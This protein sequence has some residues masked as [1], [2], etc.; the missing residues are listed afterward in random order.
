MLL[1]AVENGN[2]AQV[3]SILQST[4]CSE[5]DLLAVN[6]NNETAL[7]IATRLPNVQ[8]MAEIVTS[9]LCT[10]QVL[11]KNLCGFGQETVLHAAVKQALI[12]KNL[13]IMVPILGAYQL[14]E[15]VL[16]AQD[17]EG[18]T[19]LHSAMKRAPE[20]ITMGESDFNPLNVIG[21]I[22]PSCTEKV[23][24]VKNRNGDTPLHLAVEFAILC[25]YTSILES[26]LSLEG[27][28]KRVL[29]IRNAKGETV[30]DIAKTSKE[31]YIVNLISSKYS[32]EFNT[33]TNPS[34]QQQTLEPLHE[35]EQSHLNKKIET[36]TNTHNNTPHSFSNIRMQVLGGFIAVLGISAI[37]I[38]FVAL[39]AATFGIVGL[40][41]AGVGVALLLTGVGFFAG[42]PVTNY[43]NTVEPD[44]SMNL[45]EHPSF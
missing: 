1:K 44:S 19:A 36:D 39:N 45:E 20:E 21:M 10:E 3:K 4:N 22:T 26:I 40:V 8:I 41:C 6:A 15:N 31:D 23:L 9:P 2:L 17:C 37:A 43:C 33:V 32:S 34:N 11:L 13:D 7:Y 25:N 38:S 27:C 30:L 24:L 16:A 42:A 35:S 5:A 14:S 12:H 29:D 18:D 28:T